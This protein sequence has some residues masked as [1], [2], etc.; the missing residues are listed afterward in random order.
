MHG[1]GGNG[2]TTCR[3]I[4]ALTVGMPQAQR[5]PGSSAITHASCHCELPFSPVDPAAMSAR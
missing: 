1:G 2:F 3:G 5:H 4:A